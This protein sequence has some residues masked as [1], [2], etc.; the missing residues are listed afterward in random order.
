MDV[1]SGV[2]EGN[3]PAFPVPPAVPIPVPPELTGEALE[4]W[5]R[6]VADLGSDAMSVD[7][8]ALIVL[9]T[10]WAELAEADREIGSGG[11]VIRLANGYPGPNPYVKVRKEART[12]VLKLLTEFGLTPAARGGIKNRATPP[13]DLDI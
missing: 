13:A 2:L 3:P 1:E 12:V 8:A 9:A 6:F 4:A 10:A 11:T 7:R 5:Y